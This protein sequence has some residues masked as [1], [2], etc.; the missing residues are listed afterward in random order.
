[1]ES[2]GKTGSKQKPNFQG[3]HRYKTLGIRYL[4]N[5]FF[6]VP[7][8]DSHIVGNFNGLNNGNIVFF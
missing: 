3:A 4:I 2:F 8:V 1:M 7:Y 6:K 5:I